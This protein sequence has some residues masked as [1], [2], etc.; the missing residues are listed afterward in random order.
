MF[1]HFFIYHIYSL[2]IIYDT[3][4]F[5]CNGKKDEFYLIHRDS[6][7]K[8]TLNGVCVC[9]LFVAD[10]RNIN[11]YFHANFSESANAR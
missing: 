11:G 8:N 10:K 6:V 9:A 2:F 7:K 3:F 5:W 1:R 4:L